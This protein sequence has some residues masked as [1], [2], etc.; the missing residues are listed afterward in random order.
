MT[1]SC[2]FCLPLGPCL[3]FGTRK[4]TAQLS[5]NI[6][7]LRTFHYSIHCSTCGMPCSA[8]SSNFLWYFY[9]LLILILIST[10]NHG[11]VEVE[12]TS[13]DC[14]FQPPAQSR[15]S[16]GR[17]PSTVSSWILNI[18]KDGDS[19]TSLGNLF[20]C[21]ATLQVKKIYFMFKWNLCFNLCK[22]PLSFHWASLR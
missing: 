11:I 5:C 12:S 17:L 13:G 3:A 21:L 19:T 20:Q 4:S 10:F 2:L 15:G 18:W 22:C 8:A 7:K 9:F 16:K 1:T 14:L 6:C